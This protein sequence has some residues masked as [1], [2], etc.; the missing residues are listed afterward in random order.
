M[1]GKKDVEGGFFFFGGGGEKVVEGVWWRGR[2]MLKVLVEG[3]KDVKDIFFCFF[4]FW[5][6]EKGVEGVW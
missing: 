6:G 4:F 5:G 1:E 3:K 2:K